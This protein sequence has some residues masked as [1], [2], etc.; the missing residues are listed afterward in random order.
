MKYIWGEKNSEIIFVTLTWFCFYRHAQRR[1]SS[2]ENTVIAGARPP[3]MQ[4]VNIKTSTRW[5]LFVVCSSKFHTFSKIIFWHFDVVWSHLLISDCLLQYLFAGEH[6]DLTAM[7]NTW[8]L[9]KGIPLLTVKRKGPHLLLRQDRFLRTVI[10]SDPLWSALQ[11]G[12]A[13]TFTCVAHFNYLVYYFVHSVAFYFLF[14]LLQL[15]TIIKSLNLSFTFFKTIIPSCI[16]SCG[17]SL[18][19]TKQMPPALSTST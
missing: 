7:M 16:V 1:N 9:Q 5:L 17:I 6:L 8:T 12:Y 13:C 3:R 11:Q 4:W 14:L 18:W 10:P 15:L 19:H 2:Q